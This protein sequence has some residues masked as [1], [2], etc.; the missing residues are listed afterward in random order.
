M[1][2]SHTKNTNSLLSCYNI[3][4]FF[5]THPQTQKPIKNSRK[6]SNPAF[7]L[8]SLL[9]DDPM[10]SSSTCGPLTV[11]RYS[12]GIETTAPLRQHYRF[13]NVFTPAP[14]LCVFF[15]V[16]RP[17]DRFLT[18]RSRRRS[19]GVLMCLFGL[20]LLSGRVLIAY[21]FVMDVV[22]ECGALNRC[23]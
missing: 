15:P 23:R 19:Y 3:A 21:I 17:L 22:V 12:H 16:S 5:S 7:F 20:I 9:K 14:S 10:V 6:R 18:A 1:N 2:Y 11:S 8:H 4:W 13:C